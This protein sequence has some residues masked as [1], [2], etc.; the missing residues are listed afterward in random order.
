MKV[1]SFYSS[2]HFM[3]MAQVYYCAPAAHSLLGGEQQQQQPPEHAANPE[4]VAVGMPN[5]VGSG[6]S[7]SVP[8]EGHH[9]GRGSERG[10]V[11]LGCVNVHVATGGRR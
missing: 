5:G 3:C 1:S 2:E 4:R 7:P 9:G 10:A 8:P 6:A 11:V